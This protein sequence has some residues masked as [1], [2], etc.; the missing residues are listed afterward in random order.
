MTE[1]KKILVVLAHPDDESFGMGGTLAYYAHQGVEVHLVCA[2]RGEVGEVPPEMLEGFESIAQLR[3]NELRCA[4]NTL[5]LT[6]V[7]FLEY[8]DSGMPGT[9][10]NDHPEALV[11]APLDEVA[12]KVTRYIR[13]IRPDVVITFDPVGGY[14]HPDH[15]AI[16]KATVRAFYAA[17]DP[18][19]FPNG[20]EPFQPEK[21]YFN[22]FPRG[23]IRLAVRLLKLFGQD[24]TQFGKNKDINLELLAGDEDYPAHVQVNYKSV[25]HLKEQADAC[26]ASQYNFGGQSP[27]VLRLFSRLTSGKDRFTR[28]YPPAQDDLRVKDLFTG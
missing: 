15:I 19:S 27:L 22:V 26:H 28:A 6:G 20:H 23:F 18:Q 13:E 17:G 1:N 14:H 11:R 16:H 2:T 12:S 25:F 8:R 10:D 7:H 4:A 21:L 3:E 5:G 9:P 24:L